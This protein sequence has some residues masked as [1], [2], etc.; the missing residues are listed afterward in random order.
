MGGQSLKELARPEEVVG[1]VVLTAS[2]EN[3][4]ALAPL[5]ATYTAF[6]GELLEILR[7]GIPSADPVLSVEAIYAELLRHCAAK[8]YPEP[9]C[10]SSNLRQRIGL[11]R[12]PAAV[13]GKNPVATD[14][15]AGTALLKQA[16]ADRVLAELSALRPDTSSGSDEQQWYNSE[17]TS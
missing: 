4:L 11:A 16:E 13:L 14:G 3:R 17:T 8:G 5:D 2:A 6:T 9:Q 7:E 1:T 10:S 12:N 15:D